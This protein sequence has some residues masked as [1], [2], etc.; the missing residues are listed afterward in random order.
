MELQRKG[1]RG[2]NLWNPHNRGLTGWVAYIFW[3]YAR[4]R[5]FIHNSQFY[6]KSFADNGEQNKGR[7][8]DVEEI[9][10]S[11]WYRCKIFF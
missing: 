6:K 7:W 10:R 3:K 2:Q 1:D 8:K 11:I 4:R 5:P 9:W